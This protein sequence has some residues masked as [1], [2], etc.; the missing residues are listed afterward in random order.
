[1]NILSEIINSFSPE[2]AADLQ[3]FPTLRS[4]GWI[5]MK[6]RKSMISSWGGSA[7]P[8]EGEGLLALLS[9]GIFCKCKEVKTKSVL[10]LQLL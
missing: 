2:P 8:L 3:N 10:K 9:N 7:S 6:M 1:M 4:H 5:H